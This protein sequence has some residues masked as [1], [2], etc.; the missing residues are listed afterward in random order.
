[1]NGDNSWI[2]WVVAAGF[3]IYWFSVSS[4][5]SSAN[6]AQTGV[7]AGSKVSGSTV[8]NAQ[9]Q[10]I[11]AITA[12]GNYYP[13][14]GGSSVP[15]VPSPVSPQNPLSGTTVISSAPS[16]SSSTG[17][18]PGVP[19]YN[20]SG[21]ITSYVTGASA[22]N[23]PPGSKIVNGQVY[24]AGGLWLGETTTVNGQLSYTPNA[25]T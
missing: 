8:Y 17:A 25:M 7:P 23:F 14:V 21:Q 1:M 20:Q 11:G 3:A 15:A 22:A 18:A 13:T 19:V 6:A 12:Q 10:V 4:A 2:F 24:A 5:T 9:G 16:A